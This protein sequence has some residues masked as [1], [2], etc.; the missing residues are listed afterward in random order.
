MRALHTRMCAGKRLGK[1]TG[2]PS[3]QEEHHQI[4]YSRTQNTRSEGRTSVRKAISRPRALA[5]SLVELYPTA[6]SQPLDFPP[7]EQS[8]V[9][10][11]SPAKN[12]KGHERRQ[13]WDFKPWHQMIF[14][15]SSKTGTCRPGCPH[16]ATWSGKALTNRGHPYM[17]PLSKGV[18]Y[19]T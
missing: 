12:T 11:T 9:H 16:G 2:V 4:S 18:S 1:S 17:C 3:G 14:P 8:S 13:G 15:P 6:S 7:T 5:L 19:V 10:H